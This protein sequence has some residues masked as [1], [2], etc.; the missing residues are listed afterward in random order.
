MNLIFEG[1]LQPIVHDILPMEKAREASEMLANFEVFGKI[2][3]E[4]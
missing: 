3:M 1:K 4:W 2:V